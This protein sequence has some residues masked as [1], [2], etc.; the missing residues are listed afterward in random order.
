[1]IPVGINDTLSLIGSLT[2][3]MKK[4]AHELQHLK[5]NPDDERAL[6]YL[7]QGL[8]TLALKFH[9]LSEDFNKRYQPELPPIDLKA[10]ETQDQMTMM[11]KFD[12]R[13]GLPPRPNLFELD[14]E[15]VE[16]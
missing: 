12:G 4:E 2:D 1:M 7:T 14:K 10:I 15:E 6:K 9:N 13:D 3:K 8:G 5:I 16:G 11:R